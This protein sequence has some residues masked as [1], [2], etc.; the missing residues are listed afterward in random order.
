[1]RVLVIGGTGL[2]GR[3]LVPELLRRGHEVAIVSRGR[4]RPEWW[5]RVAHILADARAFRLREDYDA[6]IHNLAYDA[7]DVRHAVRALRGR[8]GRFILTSTMAVYNYWEFDRPVREEDFDPAA[9]AHN[10]YAAGK[11]RA[12]LALAES[13]PDCPLTVFRPPILEG[14]HDG[15]LRT[16]FWI[17]RLLDGGP[18]L[19]PVLDRPSWVR[20]LWV[21]DLARAYADALTGPPGTYNIAMAETLRPREYVEGIARALGIANARIVEMPVARIH[22]RLPGYRAPQ[23][24]ANV[25]DTGRAERALGFR[26]TPFAGWMPAVVHAHVVG[27][28]LPDPDG[29]AFRADE[30]ALAQ[31]ADANR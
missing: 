29:Y 2:I 10:S 18:V 26:A 23:W 16:W 4:S 15:T 30:V 25:L 5:G 19:L 12:E 27:P 14:A 9:P 21:G 3:A 6:A 22:R 11:R 8:I 24:M 17:R 20:N 31:E 1:V 7:D 13:P 28:A